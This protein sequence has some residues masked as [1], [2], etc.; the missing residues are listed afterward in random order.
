MDCITFRFD[1]NLVGRLTVAK[2]KG[3]DNIININKNVKIQSTVLPDIKF[4]SCDDWLAFIKSDNLLIEESKRQREINEQNIETALQ[5]QKN[6][7]EVKFK[8]Y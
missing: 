8:T 3:D 5:Y 7:F 6:W 2:R 1:D 4:N